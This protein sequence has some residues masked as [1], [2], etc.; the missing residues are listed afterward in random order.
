M[1]GVVAISTSAADNT[2]ATG[3]T[4]LLYVDGK[5]VASGNG[6]SM[7]YKWNTRKAKAGPHTISATAR[8]AA[9]NAASAQEQVTK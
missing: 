6:N 3:I 5:L 8:D 7:N 2:G 9:G 1:T 4:Q